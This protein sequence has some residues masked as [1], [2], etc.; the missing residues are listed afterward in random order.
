MIHGDLAIKTK[1]GGFL[2]RGRSDDTI[3][4]AGKRLGPAEIEEV[5]L[6]S[7]ITEAAAIGV[8]D[9]VKGQCCGIYRDDR[10]CR[11][12]SACKDD[13]EHVRLASVNC[14]DRDEFMK[15]GNCRKPAMG[16]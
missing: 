7:G 16:R 6:N 2:L 1:A 14:I 3:K 15:Y 9:P 13:H 8:D 12:T 11:R 4:V 10:R 5:L